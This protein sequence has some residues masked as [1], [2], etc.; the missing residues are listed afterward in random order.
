[1]R[2]ERW[3]HGRHWAVYAPTG[4]L[5]CICVYKRGALAVVAL[6]DRKDAGHVAA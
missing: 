3:K 1:M 2:I 5:V 4:E 6:L